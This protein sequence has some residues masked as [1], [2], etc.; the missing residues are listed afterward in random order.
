[1]P[2]AC[3]ITPD[4]GGSYACEVFQT[5]RGLVS[6]QSVIIEE[7]LT[8]PG[9]NGRRF[10]TVRTSAQEFTATVVITTS[11]VA[12]AKTAI[13][14]FDALVGNL[15]DLA[16]VVDGTTYNYTDVH[17]T[18]HQLSVRRGKVAGA[19]NYATHN[20]YLIGTITFTKLN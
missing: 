19:T 4:A 14:A 13:E 3:T 7:E 18:G 15:C 12:A 2:T 10:R 17:C 6:D 8:T 9:V 16:H 5:D 1:M 11:T 20:G